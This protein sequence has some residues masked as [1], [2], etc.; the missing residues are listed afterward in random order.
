MKF[1][2]DFSCQPERSATSLG[3]IAVGKAD[4]VVVDGNPVEKISD[5]E[6]SRRFL[7][8]ALTLAG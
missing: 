8:M 2:K 5:I 4:I 6:K 1:F 3:A 7:R